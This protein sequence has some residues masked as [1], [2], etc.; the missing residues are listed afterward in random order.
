MEPDLFLVHAPHE[1]SESWRRTFGRDAVTAPSLPAWTPHS[2]RFAAIL[3][4]YRVAKAEVDVEASERR[5]PR[6]GRRRSC[7]TMKGSLL[8]TSNRNVLGSWSAEGRAKLREHGGAFATAVC[9]EVLRDTLRHALLSSM[10][11]LW[12][13]YH[14][15]SVDVVAR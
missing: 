13:E 6:Q 10:H 1:R 11:A 5:H 2:E 9:S 7:R 8:G 14:P 3:D 12:Y 4:Q 15:K